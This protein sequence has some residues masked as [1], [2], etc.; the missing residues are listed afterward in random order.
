MQL[1][2]QENIKLDISMQDIE[3]DFMNNMD[4]TSLFANMFDNAVDACKKCDNNKRRIVLHIHKYNNYVVIN[5]VNSIKQKPEIREGKL[6]ST[7]QNHI[8]LGMTILTDVVERYNGNIDYSYTDN[9]FET[10]IIISTIK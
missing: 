7:K 1:C 8:G 2:K 10:K 5:L 9:E 4:L 6:V 3:F